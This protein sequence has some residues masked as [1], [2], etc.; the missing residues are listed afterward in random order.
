MPSG[1]RRPEYRPEQPLTYLTGFLDGKGK[2]KR[3]SIASKRSVCPAQP[4]A[5]SPNDYH[6]TVLNA[7]FVT[8]AS[9]RAERFDE[10]KISEFF[11]LVFLAIRL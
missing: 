9:L 4:S 1:N 2:T 5:T 10:E 7:D 11:H 3:L 6:R 8:V